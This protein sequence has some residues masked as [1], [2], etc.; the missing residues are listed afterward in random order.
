MLARRQ[1]LQRLNPKPMRENAT[2]FA[3]FVRI[4]PVQRRCPGHISIG[5]YEERRGRRHVADRPSG[6]DGEPVFFVDQ[7]SRHLATVGEINE[8]R[9]SVAG[10]L[11]DASCSAGVGYGEVGYPSPYQW[12]RIGACD[13]T[14]FGTR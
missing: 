7:R 5:T 1:W 11:R 13:V 3:Q 6:S 12:M 8:Q 10:E 2:Q 14:V 4:S 9:P